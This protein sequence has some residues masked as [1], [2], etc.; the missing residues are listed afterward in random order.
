MERC[1]IS[2]S[3]VIFR[4]SFWEQEKI[5]FLNHFR[6][7]EDYE[8]WLRLNFKNP[9]GF[10]DKSL[11][12]KRSG[13][14]SQLSQTIEIDRYRVLALHRFYQQYSKDKSFKQIETIWRQEILKKI[15]ILQQGALKYNLK[16]KQQQYQNW[17]ILFNINRTKAQL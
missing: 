11:V 8:L 1:L 16:F 13:E 2:P 4:R 5:Y 6:V 17:E 14:W 9:I 7:A 15:K 3:S 10:I 12:T